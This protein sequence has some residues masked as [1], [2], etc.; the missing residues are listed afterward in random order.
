MLGSW[1]GE[2]GRPGQQF[3]PIRWNLELSVQQGVKVSE[4]MLLPKFKCQAN[5]K[6]E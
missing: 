6:G 4:V 3:A 1:S 5:Y 2:E